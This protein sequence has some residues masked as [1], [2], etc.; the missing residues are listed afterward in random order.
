MSSQYP[1]VRFMVTGNHHDC[2][3]PINDFYPYGTNDSS[4]P[5]SQSWR[6][7]S[8]ATIGAMPD[9][10]GGDRQGEMS[11]VCYYFGIELNQKLDIPIGLMHA[12][13][14]GSAVEDWISKEVLGDGKSGPCPGPIIGSMGVPSN[15]YNGEEIE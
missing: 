12:S 6:K 9:V 11:A 15:Q 4:L 3:N 1:N 5:L 8:P 2:P 7:P 10:M 14:G 13:Y